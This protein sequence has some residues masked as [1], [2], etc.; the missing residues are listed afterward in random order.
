M[1]QQHALNPN[2]ITE[3]YH[4]TQSMVFMAESGEW[5]SFEEYEQKRQCIIQ[6]NEDKPN[7]KEAIQQQE[8]IALLEEIVAMNKTIMTL[9]E[10]KLSEDKAAILVLQN[11][12][13]IKKHYQG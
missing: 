7:D 5:A 1:L 13:K 12:K 10:N 4:L 8:T 11:S 9:S 3:L 6:S 2:Q